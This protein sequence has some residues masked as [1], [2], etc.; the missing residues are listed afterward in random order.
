MKK[1]LAHRTDHMARPTYPKIYAEATAT[2]K[3][4][5]NRWPSAYASGQVVQLYK[6][7]V[8][9]RHG[10]S[11]TPY[12]APANKKH[13]ALTRWFDEDWI[14]ILTGKPCGSVKSPAYYPTCRPRATARQL[15]SAHTADAAMRKQ[16]ALHK[17]AA[18]P[19]YFRIR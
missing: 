15:T 8:R 3:Q 7:M 17:T 1:I 2:V 11:A 5:V 9:Q 4:R 6:V 10:S 18:Y 13:E 14:D 19:D 12:T 16:K